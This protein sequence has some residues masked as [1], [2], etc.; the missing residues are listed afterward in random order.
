M[1]IVKA[2]PDAL[3]DRGLDGEL[4]GKGYNSFFLQLKSCADYIA[5]GRRTVSPGTSQGDSS[6]T[7]SSESERKHGSF[8]FHLE[9]VPG[10]VRQ[11]LK[12]KKPLPPKERRDLLRDSCSRKAAKDSYG[13]VN[14][15]PARN[16]EPEEEI[17]D[18]IRFLKRE[19]KKSLEEIDMR[20]C[21]D[22]M[23]EMY[24]EQRIFI[25]ADP[26]PCISEVKEEWPMLFH[27]RFFYKHGNKLLAKDVKAIFDQKVSTY[28]P[29][30]VQ[31]ME[32]V[33]KKEVM[34]T[35]VTM[36]EGT[37]KGNTKAMEEAMLPLLCAYFKEDE[38]HLFRVLEQIL[39]TEPVD[40][41]EAT[42]LLLLSYY[43]FNLA[44]ADPVATTLEF[45][46]RETFT[47]NPSRGSKYGKGRRSRT[48]VSSKIMQLMQ[49]LRCEGL[50]L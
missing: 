37:K 1:A 41:S 32:T 11:A 35:L 24:P 15:Q 19:G 22:Y 25:N 2:F 33:P 45:L 34:Y 39:F 48:A 8:S 27:R 18:K 40:F 3:E 17:D 30:L 36:E 31:Y 47:I 13:C 26:A 5:L 46:Q 16:W 10:L 21:N 42:C 50:K 28:A 38:R 43:V 44:Y 20:L 7:Y 4:R 14:W 23:E 29:L 49:R 6:S 12:A 9:H